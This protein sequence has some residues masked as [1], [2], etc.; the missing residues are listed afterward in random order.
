LA[1]SLTML[2][3]FLVREPMESHGNL[4]NPSTLPA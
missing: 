4:R 1:I 2:E 3:Q